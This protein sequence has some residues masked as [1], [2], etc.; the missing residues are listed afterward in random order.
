MKWQS[1]KLCL[2]LLAFIVY[3]LICAI[4]LQIW[5][6]NEEMKEWRK[7]RLPAD[8][9]ATFLL[10][11]IS[12]AFVAFTNL[13]SMHYALVLASYEANHHRAVS[14]MRSILNM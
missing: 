9:A 5:S 7:T 2:N 6:L 10:C 14:E 1:L 4:Y 12:Y 3:A 11:G 8:L 13:L